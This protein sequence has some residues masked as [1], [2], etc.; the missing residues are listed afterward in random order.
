MFLVGKGGAENENTLKN[1]L[2]PDIPMNPLGFL[3]SLFL[4]VSQVLDVFLQS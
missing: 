1:V 4:C 3:D 2:D